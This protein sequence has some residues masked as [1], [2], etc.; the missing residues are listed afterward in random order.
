MRFDSYEHL[1]QKVDFGRYVI[2][3][4]YGGITLDCDMEPFRPLDEIPEIDFSPLI[5]GKSNDSRFET[6]SMTFGHLLNDE[7][8]LN[9]A[10]IAC[11]PKNPDIKRLIDSCINDRTTC[12]DYFCRVYCISTTTGQ[13]RMSTVLKDSNM[14][15]LYPD[16]L[17]SEYH[18][19]KTFFIHDHDLSWSDSYSAFFMKGYL[20]V[21]EYKKPAILLLTIIILYILKLFNMN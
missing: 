16:L 17:E 20:F 13:I 19:S 11:K 4:L 21:K 2:A 3:Y 14:T 10:F 6:C 18:N 12:E 8:F 9:N 5:V 7:W 15:I 1:I